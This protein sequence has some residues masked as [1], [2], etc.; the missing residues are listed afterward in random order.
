MMQSQRSRQAVIIDG[1]SRRRNSRNNRYEREPV[2]ASCSWSLSSSL[3]RTTASQVIFRVVGSQLN[4]H[5]VLSFPAP[6]GDHHQNVLFFP[7]NNDLSTARS[8]LGTDN[9]AVKSKIMLDSNMA[10]HETPISGH[11]NRIVNGFIPSK[12]G[13]HDYMREGYYAAEGNADSDHSPKNDPS[14]FSE[15]DN[16]RTQ[17]LSESLVSSC[18]N[19]AR[20]AIKVGMGDVQWGEMFQELLQFQKKHGHCQISPEI[21]VGSIKL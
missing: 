1:K 17:E 7:L 12:L 21:H 14:C 15:Y 5:R 18:G 3:T 19:K 13:G 8:R 6:Q 9:A 2:T 10:N 20:A 11:E 4:D 16:S